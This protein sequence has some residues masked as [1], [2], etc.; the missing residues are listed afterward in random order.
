MSLTGLASSVARLV[1]VIVAVGGSIVFFGPPAQAC[2]CAMLPTARLVQGADQVFTG[3][4]TSVDE[5]TESQQ[6]VFRV[7]V[8][9]AFK[10]DVRR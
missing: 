10:G 9:R 2:S 3:S 6:R 4:V 5:S 8:D 1:A 7:Q